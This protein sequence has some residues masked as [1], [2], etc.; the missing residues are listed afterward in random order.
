MYQLR[1]MGL[2]GR[3]YRAAAGDHQADLF[4]PDGQGESAG[5]HR[6]ERRERRALQQQRHRA[7]PRA[8]RRYRAG[9]VDAH[10]GQSGGGEI[11]PAAQDR[12][13]RRLVGEKRALRHRGGVRKPGEA[14]GQPPGRGDRL[15]LPAQR[16]PAGAGAAGA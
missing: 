3:A 8:R 11:H 1:F 4:V 9:V 12:G 7:G 13:K 6:G 5:H 16:D 10:R 14:T 2:H 15:A